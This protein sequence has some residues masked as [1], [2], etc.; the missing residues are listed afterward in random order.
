L[1]L[2]WTNEALIRLQEI[3]EFIAK[4]NPGTAVKFVDKLI[5]IAETIPENPSQKQFLKILKKEE[6]FLNFQ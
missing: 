6:S 4:D 5:S 3:E 2:R 1:K